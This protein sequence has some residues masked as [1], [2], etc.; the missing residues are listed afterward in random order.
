MEMPAL[1]EYIVSAIN[2]KNEAID[3]KI[4]KCGHCNEMV[5]KVGRCSECNTE[6][7]HVNTVENP[8]TGFMHFIYECSGCPPSRRR[9][10]KVIKINEGNSSKDD[11]TTR[12]L[13]KGFY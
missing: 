1:D 8:E 2:I 6:Y 9:A 3:V 4:C 10:Q 13:R 5:P 7:I 11:I 12:D